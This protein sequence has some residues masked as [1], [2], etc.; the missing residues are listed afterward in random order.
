MYSTGQIQNWLKLFSAKKRN[1]NIT[2]VHQ[3]KK[4]EKSAGKL[5]C[6]L[7]STIVSIPL[8]ILPPSIYPQP[9]AVG[10]VS[11]N[12]CPS[13]CGHSCLGQMGSS[14]PHLSSC[15][16]MSVRVPP[17]LHPKPH[18]SSPPIASLSPSQNRM[19]KMF[20][21]NATGKGDSPMNL[22]WISAVMA[23]HYSHLHF[24]KGQ[25][26]TLNQLHTVIYSFT[27]TNNW[28]LSMS[29][30]E[31]YNQG[32]CSKVGGKGE[33]LLKLFLNNIGSQ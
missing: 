30:C 2:K 29:H 4:Y 6:T 21:S 8:S 31:G 25:I 12:V 11:C 1:C 16:V 20:L 10:W 22:W 19:E 13:S 32:T 33:C 7:R 23:D 9:S 3:L 18:I 5:S 24:L 14:M 27:A 17:T 15:D 28:S 26:S